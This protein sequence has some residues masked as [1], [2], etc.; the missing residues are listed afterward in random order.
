MWR[1]EIEYIN[2]YRIEAGLAHSGVILMAIAILGL[3]L[4]RADGELQKMGGYGRMVV[5]HSI[6]S[7]TARLA[8]LFPTGQLNAAQT[9]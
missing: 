6:D 2:S 3:R 8:D 4:R 9:R 7:A 1:T 5:L